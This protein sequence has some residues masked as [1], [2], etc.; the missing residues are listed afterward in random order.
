MS[1]RL[2]VVHSDDL[3]M[4]YADH[5]ADRRRHQLAMALARQSGLFDAPGV[6]LVPGPPPMTDVD[7]GAMFAP[8]FIRAIQAFSAR[9]ILAAAPEARQWGVTPDVHP[10]AGMHDDSA[11]L[12]AA[13][14]Q[15]G[16]LVGEGTATSA[17]V[18]A[19]G[20]HHG[21]PHRMNGFGV[22]NDTA[23]AILALRAAGVRRI[24]YIDLDVH[25]GDGTQGFFWNDSSVLTVSVH[26]SG[27]YLFPNSGFP[28]ETGGPDAPGS[29]VNLALPP[30]AGDDAYRAA[31]SRIVAPAVRAFAPEVIVAQCGVDHHHADP[32]SHLRTTMSLYPELWA[33]LLDLADAECAGR[34][35]VLAG[36]GY[37]PCNA[38]PRAWAMLMLQM[39]GVPRPHDMPAAFAPLAASR[40]C[41]G[42][43]A[44]WLAEPDLRAVRARSA[45]AMPAVEQAI[46]DTIRESP[47][48]G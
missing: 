24:A 44:H 40:G 38:P 7:L 5:P 2:A 15:A 20:A 48:L 21:L 46:A 31:M 25:H 12:A 26:E 6:T 27:R 18:P 30:E 47:V 13:A 36:G 39:A 35:V 10:Y 17:I 14:W 32:L 22:Y 16:S 29:A 9:P 19:G 28:E 34:I 33:C 1:T 41:T 43:A 8:A 37:D 11:R 23:V 4:A 3:G 42:P 45:E